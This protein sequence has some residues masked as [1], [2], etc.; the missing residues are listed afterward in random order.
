MKKLTKGQ[1]VLPESLTEFGLSTPMLIRLDKDAGITTVRGL[2]QA[3]EAELRGY[4][5]GQPSIRKL[6]TFLSDFELR[7]GMKLG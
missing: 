6:K 5:F 1:S 3:T 2:A 4:G 7:F